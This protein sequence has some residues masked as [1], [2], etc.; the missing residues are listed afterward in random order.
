M[1]V[2]F[3]TVFSEYKD[4]SNTSNSLYVYVLFNCQK[5]KILEHIDHKKK[6]VDQISNSYKRRLYLNRYFGFKNHIIAN[7]NSVADDEI[8]NQIF[9]IGE[10]ISQYEI[11][12]D[13][14]KILSKYK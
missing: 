4:I 12:L 7:F 5:S 8:I 1:S 2:S 3:E 14:H 10:T 11:T 9:M 6:I 13:W